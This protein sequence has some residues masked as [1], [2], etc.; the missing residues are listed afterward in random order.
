MNPISRIVNAQNPFPVGNPV[1]KYYRFPLLEP[2]I[3]RPSSQPQIKMVQFLLCQILLQLSARYIF[4]SGTAHNH[5]LH[6][7]VQQPLH[8]SHRF[9][10][11]RFTGNHRCSVPIKKNPSILLQPTCLL[12][13]SVLFLRLLP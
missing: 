12:F 7:F 10:N 6:P 2:V 11:R 1:C 13:H 8:S 4:I 5:Q 9:L 3:I